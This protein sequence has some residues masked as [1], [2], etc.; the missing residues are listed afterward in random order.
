M[1]ISSRILSSLGRTVSRSLLAAAALSFTAISA[2]Y[3]HL[4]WLEE[5][6]DKGLVLRFGDF[7]DHFETS[8]GHLDAIP[9]TPGFILTEKG[10]EAAKAT[11][12][13]DGVTYEKATSATAL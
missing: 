3:A 5:T 6:P 9:E 4:V 10:P 8:P 7:N 11:R 2:G 12:G 1:Q 13:K